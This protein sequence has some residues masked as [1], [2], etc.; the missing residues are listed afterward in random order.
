MTQALSTENR[1][2]ADFQTFQQSLAPDEPAWLRSMRQ[3][4]WSRF[5]ELGFP[6]KRGN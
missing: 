3:R 6:T 2:L 4:A 1:Y 5:A